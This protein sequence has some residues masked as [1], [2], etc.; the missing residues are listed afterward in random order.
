MYITETCQCQ[1]LFVDALSTQAFAFWA[2]HY[3]GFPQTGCICTDF[4]LMRR[5]FRLFTD[6]QRIYRALAF[7][8]I[9][10]RMLS[11]TLSFD[12][13]H[14]TSHRHKAAR[15]SAYGTR[16]RSYLQRL[17]LI[18]YPPLARRPVARARCGPHRI[19]IVHHTRSASACPINSVRTPAS[20]SEIHLTPHPRP[21][22]PP[23]H[24]HR[25][26]LTNGLLHSHLHPDPRPSCPH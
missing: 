4:N 14:P 15:P 10:P 11:Q 19:H 2:S 7:S 26:A 6:P 22:S 5:R 9:Y 12:R 13:S 8:D 20:R 17:V 21:P 1:Y 24:A 3:P 18:V 25:S 23:S 16:S